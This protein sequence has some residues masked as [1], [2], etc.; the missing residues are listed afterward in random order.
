MRDNNFLKKKFVCV[1][2]MSAIF[3]SLLTCI[4]YTPALKNDFVWDDY[5]YVLENTNI[6]SLHSQ[7]LHWMLTSFHEG[8]WHPLTWLSHAIDYAFWGLDPF[9]HH[10]T[11]IVIHGLNTL[12]VF[13]LVIQL[14]MKAKETNITPSPSTRPRS[15]K[16]QALTIAGIT[17]LLFGL[18]PLQVESVAWVAERKNLLCAF[19]FLSTI[20]FYFS[21]TSSV[22]KRQRWIRFTICLLL[23][24]LA[25]LSKPMAVT[26]PVILLLLDIYPL[27]RLVHS[28]E[29]N[30]SIVCEKIP[31]FILSAASSII[32]IMAQRSGGSLRSLEQFH[33]DARLLN[34]LRSLLSYLGKMV[35]P[36]NLVPFYPFPPQTHW[37]DVPY[38]LSGVLVLAITGGC[39]WMAKNKR[40]LFLTIWLY[41]I[42]TLL[43]VIGII[44]VGSQAA[45]D[46]YTYL[47]SLS[48]FLLTG[49]GALW[50]SEKI[51][52]VKYKSI[53]VGL[54]L[55]FICTFMVLG[56]STIKQIG[57]WRN[58]EILWSYVINSFPGKVPLAH[59]NLGSD[60]EKRGRLDEAI[61]QYKKA[62]AINRNYAKAY[63]NLGV[64]YVEKG[65]LDEAIAQY[66]KVLDINPRYAEAHNNLGVIYDNKG[67]LDE[68]ISEYNK[69]L[70]INP[71]YSET[72]N[73][74]ALAYDHKGMLD[75]AISEY[76]KVLAI[77]PNYAKAHYNLG[78]AYGKKGELDEAIAEYK[79]ALDINSH[80][81]EAHNN[82][83]YAYIIKGR[84][85][86]AIAQYKK[87][88]D[89]N[90]NYA[91]AHNNL[92]L[93]YSEKRMFDESI[94][95]CK[96]AL[97][98]NPNFV[99]A[100]INLG[101]VYHKKG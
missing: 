100:H 36:S 87:A 23:F 67:M 99:E 3:I 7:S 35:I 96:K 69:A 63:Y 64:V 70:A 31:F 90:P 20:I 49:T 16:T 12:L 59:N 97:V 88:L 18:H 79:K 75:K 80:Y 2:G 77:N 29:K 39:L 78:V 93:A 30:L 82:L 50:L 68:A 43:P 58:S 9:G 101:V 17:A 25:L 37:L 65:R 26:I 92:G 46:R 19:F 24:I 52:L 53:L 62:L 84:L 38:F 71:H 72:H 95:E 44:Q 57:I 66:K 27:N 28:P 10:L 89:I 47:P 21:Y 1:M 94:S 85:D 86:E 91:E 51:K 83:G 41:Y 14:V 6:H 40:Y 48:I 81:A 34:A 61:T 8:N 54:V 45:A 11:S 13:L 60:Y 74:L 98:I 56:K 55:V 4:V 73:N 76:N 5:P 32:T 42:V 15:I 33:L 22:I